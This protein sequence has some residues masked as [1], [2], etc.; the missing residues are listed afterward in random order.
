MKSLCFTTFAALALTTSASA[1]SSP[2]NLDRTADFNTDLGSMTGVTLGPDT[3]PQV[4]A[5]VTDYS[6]PDADAGVDSSPVGLFTN[7]VSETTL[8]AA[9]NSDLSASVPNSDSAGVDSSGSQGTTPNTDFRNDAFGTPEP[10]TFALL[11]SAL[12]G[13]GILRSRKS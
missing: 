5:G 10:A 3:N 6:S 13:L 2:K 7:A 11:G 12:L 8:A 9:V 1:G 4:Q